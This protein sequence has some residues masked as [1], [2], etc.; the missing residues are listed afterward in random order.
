[1]KPYVILLLYLI[2]TKVAFS[3]ENNKLSTLKP[4]S[5]D[6]FKELGERDLERVNKRP[7]IVSYKHFSGGE[8]LYFGSSHTYDPNDKMLKMIDSAWL[9]FKPD[10][11]FWE[12]G[13]PGRVSA[14]PSSLD[15]A[16][17]KKGEPGFVRFLAKK[18]GVQDLTL[19]PSTLQIIKELQKSFSDEEIV[20]QVILTQVE[21]EKRKG[22]AHK[23]LDSLVTTYL[24]LSRGFNFKEIPTDLDDFQRAVTSVLPDLKDWKN[25]TLDMVAP[26]SIN[27][28]NTNKLQKMATISSE[29]RDRHMIT[30]LLGEVQKGR[31]VYAVVGASH[32]IVQEPA[33]CQF[34]G[35]KYQ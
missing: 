25:I 27:D 10:I 12:G 19:E 22:T 9:S 5:H 20:V 4:L 13:N 11:V 16:V 30:V 1:M 2:S 18:R 21:Q 26:K 8:L 6:E 24:R 14:L 35:I 23:T 17:T 29:V 33:L 28:I 7:Y 32:V 34:F 31:K 3:Q 15:E